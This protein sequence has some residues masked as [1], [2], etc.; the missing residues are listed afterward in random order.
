MTEGQNHIS[1]N[2][3]IFMHARLWE[4]AMCARR[5]AQIKCGKFA[6]YEYLHALIDGAFAFEAYLQYLGMQ[7]IP[8]WED[9]ERQSLRKRIDAVASSLGLKPDCDVPPFSLV[10]QLMNARNGIA[11]A[12]PQ[13]LTVNMVVNGCVQEALVNDKNAPIENLCTE[14]SVGPLLDAV[15]TVV[16]QL[17]KASGDPLHPLYVKGVTSAVI[18]KAGS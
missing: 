10:I 11:H 2:R 12:R 7:R 15:E 16:L 14:K 1:G 9:I 3:V 13:Y 5:D 17:H 8:H 4:A 6:E 18:R